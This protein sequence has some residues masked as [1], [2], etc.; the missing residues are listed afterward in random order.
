VN[1]IQRMRWWLSNRLYALAEWVASLAGRVE[2]A[3]PERLG[4]VVFHPMNWR[5]I[6]LERSRDGVYLFGATG[7]EA[8]ARR[9][10][11]P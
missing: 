9:E 1:V 7:E 2:P 8:P 6:K 5:T 3:V 4:P 10:V 11:Q